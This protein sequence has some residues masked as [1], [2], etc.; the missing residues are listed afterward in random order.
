MLSP[1][2]HHVDDSHMDV[3]H[4]NGLCAMAINSLLLATRLTG[5]HTFLL[6][7]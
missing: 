7:S 6:R 1:M 2:T 3:L 5:Q 4:G